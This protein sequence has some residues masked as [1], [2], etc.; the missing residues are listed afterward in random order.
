MKNAESCFND[1]AGNYHP[2]LVLTAYSN[3]V[4]FF[5]FMKSR[6]GSGHTFGRLID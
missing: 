6:H 5:K 3:Y 1:P 4:R 2:P